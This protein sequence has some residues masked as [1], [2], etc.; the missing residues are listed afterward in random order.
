MCR[1]R[2]W[3]GFWRCGAG[4]CKGSARKDSIAAQLGWI[5]LRIDQLAAMMEALARLLDGW[6]DRGGLKADH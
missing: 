4:V 1:F 2:S 3:R 5:N 6:Q